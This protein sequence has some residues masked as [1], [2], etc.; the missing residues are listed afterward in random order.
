MYRSSLDR[1]GSGTVSIAVLWAPKSIPSGGLKIRLRTP[2]E[3]RISNVQLANGASWPKY[4]AVEETVAFGPDD[5]RNPE[6]LNTL[7]TITVT[8][9]S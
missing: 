4:D 3:S 8:F 9:R 2:G 5:L 1:D 6:V 7:A